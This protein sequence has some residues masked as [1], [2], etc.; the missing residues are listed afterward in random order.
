MIILFDSSTQVHMFKSA[1]Y[2]CSS[3][4]RALEPGTFPDNATATGFY[5]DMLLCTKLR[6]S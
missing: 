4:D 2:K 5:R 3:R 6:K 1:Q